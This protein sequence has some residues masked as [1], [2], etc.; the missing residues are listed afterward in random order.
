MEDKDLLSY[1][2][3]SIKNKLK[4]KEIYTKQKKLKTKAKLQKRKRNKIE[5]ERLGEECKKK[6]A[7]TQDN[8][9]EKD[10][11]VVDPEDEE[12]KGEEDFDEFSEILKGEKEPKVI[13]TSSYKPTKIMYDFI[14]EFLRVIPRS[15][16]YQRKNHEIK[17]IVEECSTKGFT[18]IIIIN[19]DSKSLNAMTHIHLPYGPTAYYKLSSVKLSKD[20]PN[21]GRPINV[22]PEVIL[23]NFGPDWDN[24]LQGC[25]VPSLALALIS[26][27]AE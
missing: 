1:P 9:K 18:D 12:I 6:V 16:Y 25:S 23:N 14:L 21:C 24:V 7:K 8:T 13:I 17:K 22:K 4:R 26:K 15:V 3:S 2:T 5:A 19:E 10:E 11:T 27:G 20:I